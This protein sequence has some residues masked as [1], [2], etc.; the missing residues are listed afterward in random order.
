MYERSAEGWA[1][2]LDF[3]LLDMICLEISL[4][5]AYM[6]RHGIYN[7]FT[8]DGYRNLSIVVLFLDFAL[9]LFLDTLKNVLKRGAQ[10]EAAK[11]VRHTVLLTLVLIAYL[12]AIHDKH[13]Y[14]RV[15]IFPWTD[16]L[17]PYAYRARALEKGAPAA[18]RCKEREFPSDSEQR[19]TCAGDHGAAEKIQLR[20]L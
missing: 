9:L 5:L 17:H 3:I 10:I 16:L 11:T 8:A 4:A 2:H 6:L 12:F 18:Y 1:K 14:S 13:D 20:T 15:T 7:P 19:E